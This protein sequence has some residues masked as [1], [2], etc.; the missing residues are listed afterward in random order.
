MSAEKEIRKET[1]N[2]R[3][4]STQLRQELHRELE[5]KRYNAT[6]RNTVSILIVVA[7]IAVLLSAYLISVLRVDGVSMQ[8]TLGDKDLVL[9]IRTKQFKPGEIIGF[10][11][12]N[13]ILLKRVIG[14]PG[15]IIDMDEYGN[16]SVN[17]VK[18]DEPYLTQK[19]YGDYTD[20]VFPYQV[21]EKRYFVVGDNRRESIDSRSSA[22]GTIASDAVV[23]KVLHKIWPLVNTNEGDNT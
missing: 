15:D 21:P 1:E 18:L 4:R 23:G 19:H 13:K 6:M 11:Y 20:I 2:K 22:I 10:Y 16:I 7:A 8:P 5:K 3:P 12:N 9:T 14:S 17:G